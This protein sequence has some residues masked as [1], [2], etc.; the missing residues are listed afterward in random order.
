MSTSG[1]RCRYGLSIIQL[2]RVVEA[3]TGLSSSEGAECRRC[4]CSIRNPSTDSNSAPRPSRCAALVGRETSKVGTAVSTGSAAATTPQYSRRPRTDA[5]RDASMFRVTWPS[6]L[7]FRVAQSFMCSTTSARSLAFRMSLW[8][9]AS[10][11]CSAAA[12]GSCGCGSSGLTE[13]PALA[14]SGLADL[15]L[16]VSDLAVPGRLRLSEEP[17]DRAEMAVWG[18]VGVAVVGRVDAVV[19]LDDTTDRAEK[20]P[21]VVAGVA[22][23]LSTSFPSNACLSRRSRTAGGPARK[24][25]TGG[26]RGVRALVGART[27]CSC[28]PGV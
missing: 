4:A 12:I 26:G 1:G 23:P 13:Y 16:D 24:G 14:D 3:E 10:H 19:G 22:S 18:L 17:A 21:A 20:P 25:G 27:G 6:A 11:R 7:L 28:F 15:G 5:K 8:R 9:R 2:A